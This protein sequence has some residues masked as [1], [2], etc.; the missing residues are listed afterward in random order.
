MRSVICY[1]KQP[2]CFV[3]KALRNPHTCHQNRN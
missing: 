1:L 2:A 3:T